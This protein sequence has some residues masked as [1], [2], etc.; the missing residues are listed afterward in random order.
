MGSTTA[1]I[2]YVWYRPGPDLSERIVTQYSHLLHW[3]GTTGG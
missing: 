2:P 1:N 3:F